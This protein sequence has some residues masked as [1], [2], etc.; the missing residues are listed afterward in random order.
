MTDKESTKNSAKNSGAS[1]FGAF[2]GFIAAVIPVVV[3]M[4]SNRLSSLNSASIDKISEL[5]ATKTNLSIELMPDMLLGGV[6]LGVA[7]GLAWWEANIDDKPLGNIAGFF[8]SF[9]VVGSLVCLL[10]HSTYGRDIATLLRW[11]EKVTTDLMFLYVLVFT[12]YASYFAC[13]IQC[14]RVK[15]SKGLKK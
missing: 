14:R 1:F 13:I 3:G 5:A 6:G 7:A 11:Q 12:V 2:V 8:A 9:A 15:D 4:M 10:A